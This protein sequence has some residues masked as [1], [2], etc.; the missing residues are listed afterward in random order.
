MALACGQDAQ[1]SEQV[2]V[3]RVVASRARARQVLGQLK[4]CVLLLG[5]CLVFGCA[6]MSWT[7]VGGATLAMGA[8]TA[9]TAA[10]V[11]EDEERRRLAPASHTRQD[12]ASS[13]GSAQDAGADEPPPDDDDDDDDDDRRKKEQFPSIFIA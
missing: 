13:A 1:R 7:Q 12:S 11:A 10:S 6:H 2:G 9:F 3:G 4:T 8:M 5:S